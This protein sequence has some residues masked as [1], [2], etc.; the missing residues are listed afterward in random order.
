MPQ[1]WYQLLH[2]FKQICSNWL[3]PQDCA[4]ELSDAERILKIS[5]FLKTHPQSSNFLKKCASPPSPQPELNREKRWSTPTCLEHCSSQNTVM[6]SFLMPK[7]NCETAKAKL[8]KHQLRALAATAGGQFCSPA[9]TTHYWRM[10]LLQNFELWEIKI[11]K[12][13]SD[14]I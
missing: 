7:W 1:L 3:L 14:Q 2:N 5:W 12:G 6:L 10:E 9:H 8:H 11:F 4:S 13:S